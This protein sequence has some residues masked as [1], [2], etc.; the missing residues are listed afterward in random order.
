MDLISIIVPV[1]NNK[2]YIS[3]CVNS[4]SNQTYKNLEIILVDD[5]SQDNSLK[6]CNKLAKKD[7][8]IKVI[9]KENSGVSEARNLGLSNA[10]GEYILFVDG[11]DF[12]P[13][14][15]T[16]KLHNVIKSNNSDLS[17]GCWCKISVKGDIQ[18]H[19]PTETISTQNKAELIKIMDYEEIKGPV[20]KLY[21]TDIIK[22]A[23]LSFPKD[24][25]ISEDTIF[26]YKYLQKCDKISI[27]DE[28]VYYYNR[29][30]IGS[31]TTK[32]YD[33][34]NISSFLCIVEYIKNATFSYN[35]LHN[36][37]LQQKIINQYNAVNRYIIFYK[38]SNKSEAVLK[39][40]ETYNLFKEYINNDIVKDNLEPFSLYKSSFEYLKD[41]N[42]D[43]L[44][45]FLCENEKNKNARDKKT[46]KNLLIN[47]ILKLKIF[48]IY[49][50]RIDYTK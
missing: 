42:Y 22:S 15:A 19:H 10:V 29:L 37:K 18:N 44:F 12:L 45:D 21:K 48:L 35:D 3:K 24:I 49:T 28:N 46:F 4:L 33:K 5:G 11:D 13:L 34:F 2:K 25:K 39:L 9:H 50:L 40:K 20:A 36:L 31:A 47:S 6:I 38:S 27:I 32:Y 26:V 17:C 30:S 43:G 23:N 1:Y 41:E 14:D 7:C 8:R 16:E